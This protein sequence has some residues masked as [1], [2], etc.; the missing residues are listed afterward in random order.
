MIMQE[1]H[2][3]ICS[4]LPCDLSLHRIEAIWLKQK[5]LADRYCERRRL[6]MAMAAWKGEMMEKIHNKYINFVL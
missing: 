1:C 3:V 4:S 2:D 6:K 5:K